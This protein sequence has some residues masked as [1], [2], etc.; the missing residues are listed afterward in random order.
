M[1]F[2]YEILSGLLNSIAQDESLN[3]KKID[4]NIKK[5]TNYDWFKDLY[6]DENYHRLFLV[7]RRIRGYLQSTYRVKRMIKYEKSR[8]KL[9]KLLAKEIIKREK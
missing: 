2:L 5:L 1:S 8:N 9:K 4:R 3:T 6:D 7:N